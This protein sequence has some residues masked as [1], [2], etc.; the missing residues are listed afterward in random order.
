MTRDVAAP[1]A[2]R[3][4]DERSASTSTLDTLVGDEGLEEDQREVI[5]ELAKARSRAHGVEA[6]EPPPRA[7]LEGELDGLALGG[8][9]EM[10]ALT[11]SSSKDS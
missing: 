1:P 6:A 5:E 11:L 10:D 4:V 2:R 9:D 3:R 7:E 8:P